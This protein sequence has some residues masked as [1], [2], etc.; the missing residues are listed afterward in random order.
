MVAGRGQ[1]D[2]GRNFWKFETRG[3]RAFPRGSGAQIDMRIRFRVHDDGGG[4][5][6]IRAVAIDKKVVEQTRYIYMCVCTLR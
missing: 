3:G 1:P 5:G 2:D 6:G 4:D